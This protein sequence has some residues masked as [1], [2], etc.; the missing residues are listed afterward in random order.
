MRCG[1]V[2]WTDMRGSPN[3]ERRLRSEPA[4][5][6]L[7]QNDLTIPDLAECCGYGS[8]VY[9]T[10]AFQRALKTTPLGYR[11]QMRNR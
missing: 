4:N 2:H 11:K 10:D 6:L 8:N 9:F 1:N 5:R 7:V 3:P